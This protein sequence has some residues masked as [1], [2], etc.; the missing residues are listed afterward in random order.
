MTPSCFW[1]TW[2]GAWKRA[3]KSGSAVFAGAKEISFTILAMTLSLGS[4][5][6]PLVG[7][8]G[9]MG[10]VFREFGVTIIVS[11]IASGIVSLTLTPMMCSRVLKEYDEA[12]RSWL[13]RTAHDIEDRFLKLYGPALTF[14]LK[15]WY[16]SV[17]AYLACFFGAYLVLYPWCPRP[18]S[19]KETAA[20]SLAHG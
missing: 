6:I 13:E 20:S 16:Y 19:L 12:S 18:S 14:A 5:F 7:M 11:I 9:M 17:L 10:R 3:K 4:V 1:K 15:H 2:C 8:G